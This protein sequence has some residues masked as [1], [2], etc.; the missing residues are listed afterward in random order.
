M[1][2]KQLESGDYDIK[3]TG[4][5]HPPAA[6]LKAWLRDLA[7]PLIPPSAYQ[8]CISLGRKEKRT[9]GEVEKAIADMPALNR[10]VMGRVL[11]LCAKINQ[12]E[13]KTR[14]TYSNLV[15]SLLSMVA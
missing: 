1:L 2:R 6:L 4:D 7:E 12:N 9:V 13:A 3:E 11:A 5:P 14:M 15:C 10:K 8:S